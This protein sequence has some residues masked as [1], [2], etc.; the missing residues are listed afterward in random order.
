M[1]ATG[2]VL[3]ESASFISTYLK[4]N[5]SF[6]VLHAPFSKIVIAAWFGP[7]CTL[8]LHIALPPE[9]GL[10]VRIIHI[11]V[12]I[13]S[14]K[15]GLCA[16]SKIIRRIGLY[17]ER[18]VSDTRSSRLWMQ[19]MRTGLGTGTM[20]MKLFLLTSFGS[21]AWVLVIPNAPFNSPAL[22][23]FWSLPLCVLGRVCI[24]PISFKQMYHS[25][26]A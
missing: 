18:P 12:L 6:Y 19:L 22:G 10:V 8:L 21:R 20:T 24:R 16:G 17:S 13:L 9:H 2:K 23:G 3:P 25:S 5:I 11:V 1:A 26:Y 7:V 14:L 15:C 4:A